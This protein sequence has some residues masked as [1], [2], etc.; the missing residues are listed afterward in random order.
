[1]RSTTP[2]GRAHGFR[3]AGIP[4]GPSRRYRLYPRGLPAHARPATTAG[5]DSPLPDYDS[6]L[7]GC[8]NPAAAPL[9]AIISA[10]FLDASSIISSSSSTAPRRS[11]SVARW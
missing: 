1:M 5:H 9:A 4:L 11:V 2:L 3:N 6:R 7:S 8:D 10:I